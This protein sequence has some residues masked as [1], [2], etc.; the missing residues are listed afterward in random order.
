MSVQK[1]HYE[2]GR[3]SKR[4]AVCVVD[5]WSTGINLCKLIVERNIDLIVIWKISCVRAKL[6]SLCVIIHN[7]KV[8]DEDEATLQELK[9]IEEKGDVN[10][11]CIIPGSETGVL[12]AERLA[13]KFG[14]PTNPPK[15][16]LARRNKYLMGETVRKAGIRAVKQIMANCWLQVEEFIS[17]FSPYP[18]RVVAKPNFG[19]GSDDVFLCKSK[20]ELKK[21]FITI[22]GKVNSLGIVND[23]A[24]VQEFLEGTEYA[25]DTMTRDGYH[26]VVAMW[27][28][29]K[30]PA[31]GRFNIL[32]GIKPLAVCGAI[33]HQLR[34]YVLAVM[35]ALEIRN[36]P[37]HAEVIM[38]KTGP[39]LVEIGCRCHG[40][41]A[42]WYDVA[43]EFAGQDQLNAVID[44]FAC[45]ELYNRLPDYVSESK[46]YG[47]TVDLVAYSSKE[48]C[49]IPG[50]EFVQ[51]LKS[52]HRIKLF[53]NIGDV[54]EITVDNNT[55]P[56]E[57]I[58]I[59]ENEEQVEKDCAA[60]QEFLKSGFFVMK[61]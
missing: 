21:A 14:T 20:D 53:K 27:S 49:A 41:Y 48:L 52:F 1:S 31:N 50:I 6:K 4:R 25:I 9:L 13:F 59:H 18:F 55:V 11:T 60:I 19:A 38:T 44:G 2:K 33:Q 35:D 42:Y 10:I 30:Q 8:D 16:A 17:D 40:G 36:G 57:V 3:I 15:L 28:Y 45:E 51:S 46:R 32:F 5:P 37:A 34:D 23:G 39:C 43:K 24:L 12:L 58:L 61:E 26:K 56:G 7:D 47:R 22:N 54:L 29:D